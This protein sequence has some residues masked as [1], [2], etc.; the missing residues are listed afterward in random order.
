MIWS[1]HESALAVRRGALPRF[2]PPRLDGPGSLGRLRWPPHPPEA[3]GR[4]RGPTPLSR[5]ERSGVLRFAARYGSS[6]SLGKAS[7]ARDAS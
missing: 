1:H 3:G 7:P 5:S 4:L 2:R 6:D